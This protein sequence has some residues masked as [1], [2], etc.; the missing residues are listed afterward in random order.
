MIV[1]YIPPADT[2]RFNTA[3]YNNI[4]SMIKRGVSANIVCFDTKNAVVSFMITTRGGMIQKELFLT[5]NSLT[6]NW[7]AFAIQKRF[8]F[9]SLT[10]ISGIAKQI[11]NSAITLK[12]KL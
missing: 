4:A 5:Y 10:E 3:I 8:T 12:S 6:D 7:E 1:E 2:V 11:V 9:L